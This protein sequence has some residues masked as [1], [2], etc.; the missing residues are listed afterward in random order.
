MQAKEE[1][2]RLLCAANGLNTLQLPGASAEVLMS[3]QPAVE[4]VGDWVAGKLHQMWAS[5]DAMW[6]ECPHG[7]V[8]AGGSSAGEHSF[9][10]HGC[11][12][13]SAWPRPRTGGLQFFRQLLSTS[14]RQWWGEHSPPPAGHHLRP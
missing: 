7:A 4:A 5:D 6:A 11:K 9:V 3:A 13:L 2:W 1:V 8:C 10:G 12:T 14:A